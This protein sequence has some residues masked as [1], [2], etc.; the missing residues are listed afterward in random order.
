MFDIMPFRKRNEDSFDNMVRTFNDALE[1]NWLSPFHEHFNS[2]R[3]DI[4]EKENA[5]YI[6]AEFPGVSKED[7]SIS[8]E[9]NRLVIE[10]K[11]DQKQEFKDKDNHVIRQERRYGEFKRSFYLDNFNENDITAKLEDGVLKMEIPKLNPE[12]TKHKEIEIH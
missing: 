5:Y 6:E 3:A 7:I 8:L 12:K 1:S 4:V 11:N 10:A 2:F 9:D